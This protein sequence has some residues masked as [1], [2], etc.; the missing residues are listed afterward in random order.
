MGLGSLRENKAPLAWTLCGIG[1]MGC[2]EG[3]DGSQPTPN[4]H[5]T[6]HDEVWTIRYRRNLPRPCQRKVAGHQPL[7]LHCPRPL[8]TFVPALPSF[9]LALF[10]IAPQ[11]GLTPTVSAVRHPWHI[12]LLRR[13]TSGGCTPFRV[14]VPLWSLLC[15]S[16]Q[17]NPNSLN[18]RP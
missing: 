6:P 10:E 11:F 5:A 16:C 14:F 7:C 18:G 3:L 15:S 4:W 2:L 12:I 13:V 9:W 17:P 1:S 8:P